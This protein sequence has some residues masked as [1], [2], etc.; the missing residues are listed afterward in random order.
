MVNGV[1]CRRWPY[2]SENGLEN[3]EAPELGR[4]VEFEL[5][6]LENDGTIKSKV[7]IRIDDREEYCG[8]S[9]VAG[10]DCTEISDAPE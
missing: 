10:V 7:V 9:D 3:E 2:R 8:S 1:E 6:L 4:L 5:D